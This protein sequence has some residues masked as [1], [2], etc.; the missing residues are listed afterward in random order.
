MPRDEF[1]GCIRAVALALLGEPNR[2]LSSATE[3]RFGAR[4]SL[5][6]DLV[7]A[8]WHDHEA[9]NGGGV[10]DLVARQT[11]RANGAA[12]DWLREQGFLADA[13]AQHE[14]QQPRRIVATYDYCNEAGALVFQVCR[15]EPKSFLQRRPDGNGGWSWSVKGVRQVPYRLFELRATVAHDRV[16]IVE[17]ER[18][19]DA[20]AALG[21]VA[22]TNAGG[23]GKWPA[24]LSEHL[25]GCDVVLLPDN[26]APGRAHAERVARALSGVAASIR[27]VELPGLPPKGD[28]SDWIDAGGNV[29][30]L[31]RLANAA[32]LWGADAGGGGQGPS[33]AEP[34]P[35]AER[36]AITL[37]ADFWQ[38][39][40]ELLAIRAFARASLVSPDALLGQALAVSATLAAPGTRLMTLG[41]SCSGATVSLYVVTTAASGIGKTSA[42]KA[43]RAMMPTFDQEPPLD[44][45][46]GSG[47][48]LADAFMGVVEV[49]PASGKKKAE[50]ERRQVRHRAHFHCDEAAALLKLL[51]RENGTLGESLRR[52]FTG[53]PLG[54][55][56]ATAERTRVVREYALSFT[57][58]ATEGSIPELL[59]YAEVGLP[60]RFV[61]LSGFDF[62]AP[63]DTPPATAPVLQPLSG[64]VYFDDAIVAELRAIRRAAL[65]GEAVADELESHA[66]LIRARIAAILAG[67]AGRC[68]VGRDDWQLAGV[69]METS[70]AVRSAA[71]R[72]AERLTADDRAKR[73]HERGQTAQVVRAMCDATATAVD[74][75][76]A[77]LRRRVERDGRAKRRDLVQAVTSKSRHLFEAALDRAL[78]RGLIVDAGGDGFTLGTNR[79]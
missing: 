16:F 58:N 2:A 77:A 65:R 41:E 70:R 66:P 3:L 17:G 6:V 59:S 7:K 75:I 55:R 43:R 31:T 13:A 8:V 45:P 48:G 9:G 53:E 1:P 46:P 4:G 22:T 14:R 40:P 54:Q 42:A 79:P 21:V 69:I 47:E 15:F 25:A 10:L 37:P 56:N 5:S 52:A 76:A 28:A 34:E 39:R 30:D 57:M 51:R 71:M 50:V 33:A 32:P 73:A 62:E 49:Q 74:R 38:A 27:V 20:L 67:W 11:G 72:K 44:E 64:A 36:A 18:D 63:E 26:D 29:A 19:V 60:Q 24:E 78:E 23:A 35:A 61:W 68:E 12:V